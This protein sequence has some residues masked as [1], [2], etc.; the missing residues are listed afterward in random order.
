MSCSSVH[1]VSSSSTSTISNSS[2]LG[3]RLNVSASCSS[4]GDEDV[5]ADTGVVCCCFLEGFL[6]GFLNGLVRVMVVIVEFVMFGLV[7]ICASKVNLL[8]C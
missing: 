4:V 3:S 7:N 1:A 5:V 2:S 6:E 8:F